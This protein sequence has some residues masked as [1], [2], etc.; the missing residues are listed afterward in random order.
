MEYCIYL[1]PHLHENTA[2]RPISNRQAWKGLLSTIVGD[3]MGI[4]SVAVPLF[5]ITFFLITW[6][7][8]VLNP[9]EGDVNQIDAL[10]VV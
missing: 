7:F 2:S 1:R 9:V 8:L 10:P 3:Q 4:V 6:A 5:L